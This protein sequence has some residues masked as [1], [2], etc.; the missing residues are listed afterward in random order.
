MPGVELLQSEFALQA[1]AFF[2]VANFSVE[3]GQQVER[4]IRGLKIFRVGM[5][6]V[7]G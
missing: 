7:M 2:A 3:S 4:D 6:D 1:V 5:G